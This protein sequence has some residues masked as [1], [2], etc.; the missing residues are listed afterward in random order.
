M[1]DKKNTDEETNKRIKK[2][3]EELEHSN[4][5][6]KEKI[7]ILYLDDEEKNLKSFK[8]LLRREYE[9]S[10]ALTANEAYELLENNDFH[11]IITDQ[12]MPNVTGTEFL[13]S[14]IPNHAKPVRIILSGYADIGDI[15]A[16]IDKGHINR[17][18]TKPWELEDMKQTIETSYEML[19]LRIQNQNLLD[20]IGKANAQLE[21]LMNYKASKTQ[22]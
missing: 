18:M 13:E 5:I 21:Q 16:S 17:Y 6:Q 7:R 11:V 14:I 3:Y 8:S 19:F 15:R 2:I 1:Q 10:I 4:V 12:R 20:K 22:S 9:I